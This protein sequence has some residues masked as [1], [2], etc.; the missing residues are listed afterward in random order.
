MSFQIYHICYDAPLVDKANEQTDE[1][2]ELKL[3]KPGHSG[4][5]R[6]IW[7]FNAKVVARSDM[8]ASL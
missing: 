6:H 2:P 5:T 3:R 1:L 8:A 7:I 4:K